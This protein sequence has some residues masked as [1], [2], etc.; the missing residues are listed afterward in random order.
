MFARDAIS[1]KRIMLMRSNLCHA[2]RCKLFKNEYYFVV[3]YFV[4]ITG[5]KFTV[6][7]VRNSHW[8][9]LHYHAL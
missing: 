5:G 4:L 2:K 1:M 6:N 8:P 9:A 3:F 7:G